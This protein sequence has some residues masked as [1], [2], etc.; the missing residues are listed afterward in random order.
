M[1]IPDV[2]ALPDWIT[3]TEASERIGVSRQ[4]GWRMAVAGKWK[5]LH[6]IGDSKVYVVSVEETSQK[7]FR[8]T[9]TMAQYEVGN[10][11]RSTDLTD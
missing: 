4:H 3:L 2:P 11:L 9:G 1:K 8:R 10:E 5:T 6:R 7:L